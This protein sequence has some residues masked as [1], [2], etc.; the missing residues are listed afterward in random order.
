M[1][2]ELDALKVL[3]S[4]IAHNNGYIPQNTNELVG[5]SCNRYDL[6]TLDDKE[7][8]RII[9]AYRNSLEKVRKHHITL[10]DV[11]GSFQRWWSHSKLQ[12]I[13]SNDTQT[14]TNTNL[15]ETNSNIATY[16]Y[17]SD[18]NET[19]SAQLQTYNT[20]PQ[21]QHTHMKL[22][23]TTN[24]NN[25]TGTRHHQIAV[26]SPGE[27]DH[28][29][30]EDINN[31][32]NND[33]D[34]E[35]DYDT[36]ETNTIQFDTHIELGKHAIPTRTNSSYNCK[37]S[38]QSSKQSSLNNSDSMCKHKSYK[39]YICYSLCLII[40]ILISISFIGAIYSN[41]RNLLI[42][43]QY[44]INEFNK[45]CNDSYDKF[46]KTKHYDPSKT[47]LAMIIT[48]FI[49]I[50][51][52]WII[53]T[54]LML[55]IY[56]Y[57]YFKHKEFD[58]YCFWNCFCCCNGCCCYIGPILIYFILWF[59]NMIF[60]HSVFT[61]TNLIKQNCNNDSKIYQIIGI[62]QYPI[63][64]FNLICLYLQ[65]IALPSIVLLVVLH[66]TRRS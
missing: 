53:S 56:Y 5:Y 40:F 19:L 66:L 6:K 46:V 47:F 8:Q 49:H 38:I 4:F 62:Q 10:D 42:W 41:V 64:L 16:T 7:A 12:N 24:S 31:K 65:I 55:Y 54:L 20:K 3:T 48:N 61:D 30:D 1:S 13:E 63:C 27:L 15:N 9:T 57:S 52:L 32:H 29:Y 18:I 11:R 21:L 33:E 2:H 37:E 23:L 51:L 35:S 26:T 22:T 58:E 59:L 17:S 50:G 44:N 39:F 43:K 28:Y 45:V 25:N 36:D 34:I 14:H 60:T